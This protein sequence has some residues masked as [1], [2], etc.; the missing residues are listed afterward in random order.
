LKYYR[1]IILVVAVG[2]FLGIRKWLDL[3]REKILDTEIIREDMDEGDAHL[4]RWARK[5]EDALIQ[6]RLARDGRFSYEAVEYPEKD[7]IRHAG[8]HQ[9]I[10]SIGYQG[11]QYPRLVAVSDKGDTII[12]HS[13]YLTRATI[14][15]VDI[16]GLKK[17]NQI[18]T[19]S[20]LFYR[21]K[22]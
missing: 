9:I 3:N 4:G 13:V 17:D 18:D 1:A 15:N 6:F 5:N 7:T 19:P 14:K 11:E 22:D 20:I 12:N 8:W 21:I 10:P 2:A 16:L